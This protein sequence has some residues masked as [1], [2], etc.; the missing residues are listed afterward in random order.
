M[1]KAILRE[2]LLQVLK[3]SQKARKLG[4]ELLKIMEKIRQEKRP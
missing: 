4:E 1:E 2:E 3:E